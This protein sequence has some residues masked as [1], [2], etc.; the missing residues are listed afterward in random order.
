[1]C[2]KKDAS[3]DFLNSKK[4]DREIKKEAMEVQPLKL[5]L[6]GGG[7]S[8]KSTIFKQIISFQDEKTKKENTPSSDSIVRNIYQN[9]VVSIQTL[10]DSLYL[11][12]LEISYEDRER[13]KLIE[14]IS[15]HLEDLNQH[16]FISIAQDLKYFW[17]KEVVQNIYN[18]P[19]RLFNLNDSAE[20]FLNGIDKYAVP[21]YKPNQTDLLRVRV[22]TTGI[23]EADFSINEL[24]FKLIDVGG[25][26]NQ[27]RKWIHCFQNITCVL[28]VTSINDYDTVLEED[29]NI[30]RLDDSLQIF[31]EMVNSHWF[32]KSAF[33][34][35]LNKV[36]LFKQKI[37]KVPLSD[38]LKDFTGRN[39]SFNETS[40]FIKNK[41]LH[42][43][44]NS[45]RFIYH[46]F[47]CALDTEAIEVVFKSIQDTL[48]SSITEIL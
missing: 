45:E 23:V 12:D 34:L 8:G 13:A 2:S 18:N 16:T 47:T 3:V 6:L 5:L 28:F 11:Y 44:K 33:V 42:T 10:L 37:K 21:Q 26:K 36:D 38:H 40:Q 48:L 17:A 32:E 24:P 4:I 25:Q 35:F 31:R 1:M 22:K 30:K 27:R 15:E 46:H 19:N 14:N 7:E 41:F 20:Y 39:E 9:I 43:N 29:I